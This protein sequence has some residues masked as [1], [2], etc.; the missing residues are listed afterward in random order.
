MISSFSV[1]LIIMDHSRRRAFN[2][3]GKAAVGLGGLYALSKIPLSYA[4][5]L[6]IP[7]LS[8]DPSVDQLISDYNLQQEMLA[9]DMQT[10]PGTPVKG[11]AGFGFD[12][13]NVNFIMDYASQTS[14]PETAGWQIMVSKEASNSVQ[15]TADCFL[16]AYEWSPAVN[17]KDAHINLANPPAYQ[18]PEPLP[19]GFAWD[20]A[21]AKSYFNQ[22]GEHVIFGAQIPNSYIGPGSNGKYGIAVVMYLNGSESDTP[23]YPVPFSFLSPKTWGAFSTA[24]PIPEMQFPQL[25]IASALMAPLFLLSWRKRRICS[26]RKH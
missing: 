18:N 5:A 20:A 17:K 16:V 10:N 1:R 14:K 21:F 11:K 24:Q 26:N 23:G 6:Q 22:A 8:Y 19:E 4:G 3:L 7:K 2:T 12:S 25:L 15:I 9:L 13:N